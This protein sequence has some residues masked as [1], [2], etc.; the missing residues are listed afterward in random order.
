[1]PWTDKYGWAEC[2]LRLPTQH[3][4]VTLKV[5]FLKSQYVFIHLLMIPAIVKIYFAILSAF[6]SSEIIIKNS[7]ISNM[8]YLFCAL[9]ALNSKDTD[10]QNI[11]TVNF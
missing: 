2:H 6:V 7:A 9:L 8:C 5:S 3:S 4:K 10:F 11:S 1:M